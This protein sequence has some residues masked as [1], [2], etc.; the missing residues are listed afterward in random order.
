LCELTRP[1]G[2]VGDQAADGRAEGR[3]INYLTQQQFHLLEAIS[4]LPRVMITGGAGTGKTVMAGRLAQTLAEAGKR[5]PLVRYNR[6]LAERLAVQA[7]VDLPT[8]K[9]I[10]GH[11]TLVMVERH[12]HA[13]GAHIQRAMDKLES[14]YRST[15]S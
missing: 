7:G 12:A 2:G 13:T 8:V 15:G 3:E 1:V 5:T 4:E 11:K 9:R 14:R 6:P 10:S